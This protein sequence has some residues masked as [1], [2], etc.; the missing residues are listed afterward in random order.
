M[1]RCVA[2]LIVLVA[3]CSALPETNYYI[4][5][6]DDSKDAI[7][8]SNDGPILGL[9]RVSIANY[10]RRP[11]IVTRTED[12]QVHAA[13]YHRW[14]EPLQEGIRRLLAQRMSLG[15]NGYRVESEPLD[16]RRWSYELNVE[17]DRFHSTASGNVMLGGRWTLR[18]IEDGEIVRS[19]GFGLATVMRGVGYGAAVAAQ[20]QLLGELGGR[21]AV[22]AKEVMEHPSLL[23]SN[24]I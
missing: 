15:L 22:A 3:G 8:Q 6:S 7:E 12:F 9:G 20:T 4:L 11:G 21:I 13:T 24:R 5:A 1:K 2:L 17:V 14:A 19:E 23:Q 10:L 18:R 16:R